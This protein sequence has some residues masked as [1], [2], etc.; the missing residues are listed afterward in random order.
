MSSVAAIFA[1]AQRSAAYHQKGNRLV[2]R[3]LGVPTAGTTAA[4]HPALLALLECIDR[5]LVVARH[6]AIVERVAAFTVLVV[7]SHADTLLG[8]VLEH[9]L[10]R[11][12]SKAAPVRLH[13][14]RLLGDMLDALPVD[15]E[16]DS[17][18]FSR[19]AA[20]L[21]P[22]SRDRLASVRAATARTL[23]RLQDDEAAG[24]AEDPVRAQLA[25]LAAHDD[26]GDVRA[27]ALRAVQ[28]CADTLPLVIEHCRDV[29]PA[30]RLAG[31]AAAAV[32][33]DF[34]EREID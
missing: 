12:D 15:A 8:P 10:L 17:E 13:A 3:L 16:L 21:L 14:I 20:V 31:G 29:A 23:A 30:V 24:T 5:T 9:C 19:A 34:F 11:V 26:S 7:T 6:E 28:L 25:W 1:E 32:V 22:R 27:A 2:D 4:P 18:F 33:V